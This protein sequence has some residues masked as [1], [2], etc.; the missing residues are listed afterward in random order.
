MNVPLLI[1]GVGATAVGVGHS[2]LGERWILI[3]LFRDG[4]VPK[5]RIG[6]VSATMRMMRFTWH[7]FTVVVC[8]TA[9]FLLARSAGIFDGGSTAVRVVALHWGVFAVAVLLMSRGRHGAWL[10]GSLV[11]IAA[12]LGTV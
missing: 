1:A 4:R 12:W 5:T 2:Y 9:G 8:S 6:G 11:A 7:F 10:L 3:P